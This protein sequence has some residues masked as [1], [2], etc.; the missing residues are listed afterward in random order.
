M[1]QPIRPAVSLCIPTFRRPDGL[2]KLLANVAQLDYQGPLSV[3]VVD[4]DADRPAGDVVLRAMS[5]FPFP[6]TSIVE[7]RRGQTYVYN[8]GFGAACPEPTMWRCSTTTSI[9]RSAG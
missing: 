9:P 8:T 1:N 7:P 6:L 4:N 2:R 3:I 5:A